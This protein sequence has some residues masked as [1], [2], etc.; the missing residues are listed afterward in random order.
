MEPESGPQADD[1]SPFPACG[2]M[3]AGMRPPAPFLGLLALLAFGLACASSS[4]ATDAGAAAEPA[5]STE[6]ADAEPAKPPK[7]HRTEVEVRDVR[8]VGPYV[9]ATLA[10]RDRAFHFFFPVSTSCDALIH[11]GNRARYLPEGT[12]GQVRGE[13]GERC[14][15]VGVGELPFWRDF[16]PRRRSAY[17]APRE[18]AEFHTIHEGDEFLLVR[19]RFPLSVELRWPEPMDA[20]AF[21]PPTEACRAQL[22]AGK[23]TMEFRARGPEALVLEGQR[24]AETCPIR[25]LALPLGLD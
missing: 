21:L 9:A 22:D 19:G 14:S 1:L 13:Q 6:S 23:T 16:Q 20:V 12:F 2:G 7:P 8:E 10:G 17:L 25:G 18:Q 4:P 15:P 11:E 5:A 3:L 24:G